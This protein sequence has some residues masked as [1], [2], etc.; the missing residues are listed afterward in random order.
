M[1]SAT[2]G[3]PSYLSAE[4]S[5]LLVSSGT[6]QSERAARTKGGSSA[7]PAQAPLARAGCPHRSQRGDGSSGNRVQQRPQTIP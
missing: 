4:S 7:H 5:A 2:A 3:Q 6:Q 1:P